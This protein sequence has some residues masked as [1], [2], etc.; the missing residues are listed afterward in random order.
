M[1]PKDKVEGI[2]TNIVKIIFASIILLLLAFSLLY[3]CN[4]DIQ[5]V[6]QYDEDSVIKNCIFIALAIEICTCI[7]IKIKKNE[8]KERK[9][10]R[11]K[12]FILFLIIVWGFFSIN[13]ILSTKLSPRA[14]Q[15]YILDV[16]EN[17]SN[18]NYEDFD[19]GGYINIYPNQIGIVLVCYFIRIFAKNNTFLV[20]QILNVFALII[21]Y[22]F[23]CLISKKMTNKNSRAIY[24]SILIGLMLYIQMCFY[25][26]FVYGNFLGLMFSVMGIYYELKYFEKGKIYNIIISFI[27][28]VLA[29]IIKSNYLITLIAM[30]IIIIYESIF[31]EKYRNLFLAILLVFCYITGNKIIEVSIEKITNKELGKGVP[32]LA[33]IEMGLQ[34][35][36]YASGW[37]NGYNQ[38]VFVNNEFNTEKTNEQVKKDLKETL[39]KH[40]NDIEY[41]SRYIIQKIT[42]QW[43]NPTFQCFWINQNRISNTDSPKWAV[44]II[45][46]DGAYEILVEYMNI[47]Q[48]L[49]LFGSILYMIL[50]FEKIKFKELTL[51]IIFIGGFLFH[52]IWEAKC[53]Y[54]VT[55]FILLIPYSVLGYSTFINH[56]IKNLE[57]KIKNEKEEKNKN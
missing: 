42:S 3:S 55:Y 30:L 22:I 21:S 28:I 25:S 27:S 18:K 50:D 4:V 8:G 36:G 19:E 43:N 32:K 9:E 7:A 57:E 20:I 53:Q 47:M 34:E 54:T 29:V 49:I 48:T 44:D 23:I 56:K 46:Q 11:F 15:K 26:T 14:D 35:G 31:K 13:W 40:F 6:T 17:I 52:I 37:Y 10:K 5:E 38:E 16:A 1:R 12:I 51:A 41:F 24:F 2:V 45:S 33:W 39:N